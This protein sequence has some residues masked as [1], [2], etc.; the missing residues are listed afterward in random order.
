M[1]RYQPTEE[2]KQKARANRDALIARSVPLQ[3][4]RKSGILP[5]AEMETV[6]ECLRFCYTRE[7]GQTE[8]D[9]FKGWKDKG[10]PIKKG[11]KGFPVW[12]K[13]LGAPAEGAEDSAAA[14]AAENPEA[15]EEA[16]KMSFFPL[17]Y[18]FHA[19]QVDDAA[20]PQEQPKEA[21]QE[22][23]TRQASADVPAEIM[24]GT[25]F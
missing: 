16:R 24:Q 10:R 15:G 22:A 21:P 9:T 11:E 25:L 8:W 13:P 2:Q 19:G 5:F 17:A 23:T 18:I 12:G 6:N 1:K 7:T 20:E 3:I 14:I 4:A